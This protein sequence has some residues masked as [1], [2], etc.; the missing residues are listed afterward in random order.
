[1]SYLLTFTDANSLRLEALAMKEKVGAHELMERIVLG[2]I[3]ASH[4]ASLVQDAGKTTESSPIGGS[5]DLYRWDE[6]RGVVT[7]TPANKRVFFVTGRSWDTV[8]QDLH[9]RL[10][11]GAST[12]LSDM[13]FTYGTATALDYKSITSN[14]EAVA[15]YL[16]HL[17]VAAGWGDFT[18]SGDITQGSK[19]VIRVEN[20]VFC[21]SRNASVGRRD[22]C[23]F[24]MGVCRGIA[25]IVFDCS[26]Y[27]EETKCCARAN[28]Y[29]EILLRKASES[30]KNPWSSTPTMLTR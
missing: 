14:P 24:L 11:K 17:G 23:D 9:N 22:P 29:C 5:K 18:L 13:G 6:E 2:Y 30:E 15:G 12:L 4:D 25:S 28:D 7:F 20:C 19:I 1:M 16:E 26:Y 27:A 21:R 10:R 3:N 8:E